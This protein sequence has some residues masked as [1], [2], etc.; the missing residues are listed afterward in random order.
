MAVSI[1]SMLHS[2][3]QK[4]LPLKMAVSSMLAMQRVLKNL[5]VVT[6]LNTICRV[7]LFFLD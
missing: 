3:G 6:L 7:S 4:L 2:H 1:Q 5:S